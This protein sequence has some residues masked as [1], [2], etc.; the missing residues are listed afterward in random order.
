[1][2]LAKTTIKF[3]KSLHQKK[4]RQNYNKFIVEGDKLVTEYFLHPQFPLDSLYATEA[5]LLENELMV[6][7]EREKVFQVSG[8]ELE[9]ISNLSNPNEV[10][11]VLDQ[12]VHPLN[13]DL[14]SSGLSLFLDKIMDPGNFGTILRI[15][16]WFGIHQVFYSPDSVDPY[17]PKVVQASMGAVFRVKFIEKDLM[18]LY[19]EFPG[20]HLAGTAMEG[21]SVYDYEVASGT[22]VVIGSE[23]H[24]I[25][26]EYQE[27]LDDM[28]SIPREAGSG[29]ES[30]NAAIATGIICAFLRKSQGKHI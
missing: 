6:A 25:R 7:A 29:T 28:I 19:G 2:S 3:I 5:W 1:M 24:G 9:R 26:Q 13:P 17:N 23:H 16:D 10:L 18:D 20:I 4:F 12:K 15:S 14:L 22:V 27:I 11:A 30:L 8:A 21:K